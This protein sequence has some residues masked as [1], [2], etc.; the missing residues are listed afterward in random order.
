MNG[1]VLMTNISLKG[2]ANTASLQTSFQ[3]GKND[4]RVPSEVTTQRDHFLV[5]GE[6]RLSESHVEPDAH[7]H[8]RFII[9]DG[10]RPLG[11]HCAVF[12]L[13]RNWQGDLDGGND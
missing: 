3:V 8:V 9:K 4:P 10:G 5:R 2:D 11:Q 6:N 13:F 7:L 1:Q 12:N